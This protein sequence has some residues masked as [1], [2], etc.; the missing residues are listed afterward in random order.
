M[1]N[2]AV[3]VPKQKMY[4]QVQHVIEELKLEVHQLKM[5]ETPNAVNEARVAV[6]QGAN[7]LI[8]RG[9]QATL[10]KRN[11]N[12]PV[13]EMR[14]T[15]QELGLLVLHAK[16][17]VQKPH[18]HIAFIGFANLFSS[19]DHF[20]ELFD[21]KL[22]V[23]YLE[24]VDDTLSMVELA[25]Q[26][27]A[28]IIIGGDIATRVAQ[29][30]GVPALFMECTEE[31]IKEAFNV[32]ERVAYAADLEK[33]S[34]A[35]L[36]TIL[37]T[38]FSGI[39][40]IDSAHKIT[41]VNRFM[42]RILNKKEGELLGKILEEEL[43]GMDTSQVEALLRGEQTWITSSVSIKDTQL[44]V[45]AAP[46]AYDEQSAGAIFS[47]QKM[48]TAPKVPSKNLR[49][50][51]L[52][53]Y[54]ARAGFQNILRTSP[55]IKDCMELA[56]SYAL[57]KKPVLI[58]GETGTEKDL[59]AQAIHNSSARRNQPFI[60]VNCV[61]NDPELYTILFGDLETGTKKGA[62]EAANYGSVYVS[63]VQ[64]LPPKCQYQLFRII[65][66]NMFGQNELDKT[67]ICNTRV[68][69]SASVNL[70]G[71]VR[72]GAFRE[73]LYYLLNSFSMEIPPLRQTPQEIP[74][75]AEQYIKEF[76]QQYY[77]FL[78]L[79][80]GAVKKLTEYP[81]EGNLLQLSSFCE[82]LVLTATKRVIEES[83]V[84]SLLNEIY[85]FVRMNGRQQKILVYKHPQAAKIAELLEQYD[86]NRARVAKELGISTT[87]LWRHMKKFG[88]EKKYDI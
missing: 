57:S 13:V 47:F 46:I 60:A 24:D 19:M 73:D 65:Q 43:L 66:Q 32:A 28:D 20:E 33:R 84:E 44:M 21:I 69:L 34:K 17:L 8:A 27:G 77:K 25:V 56:R 2:I 83:L 18:P 78:V 79:S 30:M 52:N 74:V 10:I 76:S 1:A 11:T 37:D 55:K 36:E 82:R 49:E 3:L 61:E 87:T 29:N 85:P 31:S 53:G 40:K 15:G 81:W 80:E 5:I 67:L 23:Y 4:E 38:A 16:Q 42:E 41:A 26:N 63:D 88:V 86:G 58:Y 9:T 50:M 45:M 64:N 71:L 54:I 48:N 14:L 75:L 22:D 35:Q 62:L 51:Y 68:L 72:S 6:E 59:F 7:I 70:A 12:I 39:I